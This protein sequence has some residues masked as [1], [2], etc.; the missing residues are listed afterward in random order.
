MSDSSAKIPVRGGNAEVQRE[1]AASNRGAILAAAREIFG[2]QGYKGARTN[3]IVDRAGVTRGALYHHFR[4]KDD[5]FEAVFLDATADLDRQART[6]VEGETGDLWTK[7]RKA[8]ASHLQLVA[9]SRA[10]QQI[11]LIDG[12]A[13]LGWQHSRDIQSQFVSHEIS[14]ALDE[15]AQQ[16]ILASPPPRQLANLIQAALNDAALTIANSIDPLLC[17]ADALE[18]F[19]VLLEGMRKAL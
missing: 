9:Q 14:K 10:F 7:M 13:V 1:R 15:L 12:P 4:D 18:A 5:L 8:F 17:A 19:N 2:L 11:L 6:A 16:G 3:D